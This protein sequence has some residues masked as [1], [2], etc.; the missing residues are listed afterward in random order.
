MRIE[1][2]INLP[3]GDLE[4]L[5]LALGC[6]RDQLQ[7][8]LTR[9]GQAALREYVECYLGRRA[10]IRGADILEHRLALLMQH[11]FENKIP[12][13]LVVSR[14]FQTTPSASRAMIRNALAKFRLQ[15]NSATAG[16]AKAVLEA[17]IW[18]GGNRTDYYANNPGQNVVDLLNQRLLSLDPT[19]KQICRLNNSSGVYLINEFSYDSLCHSFGATRVPRP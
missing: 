9:H 2:E 5:T 11:A 14:L 8:V 4:G 10:S 18:P 13:D 17:V 16:S 6:D 15:L 19:K 3:E 12:S 7:Q 1:F